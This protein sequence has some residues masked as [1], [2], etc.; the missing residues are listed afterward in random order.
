LEQW[1]VPAD[2][3]GFAYPARG[4]S[5]EAYGSHL[6][7]NGAESCRFI[8]KQCNAIERGNNTLI[9]WAAAHDSSTTHNRY[10]K[11]ANSSRNK[12]DF[13]SSRNTAIATNNSSQN[14]QTSAHGRYSDRQHRW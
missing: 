6:Y 11:A 10:S 1:E 12:T 5:D 7:A 14:I 2:Q 8:I 4:Q 9:C 3:R 13:P